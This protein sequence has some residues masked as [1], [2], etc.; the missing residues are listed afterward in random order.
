M[1]IPKTVF[2]LHCPKL[3]PERKK[4]LSR[5]LAERVP[6]RDIRWCEDY[7][8]D[9][10]FVE[11][12]KHTQKLPY[13][14]KITSGLVKSL[15]IFKTMID[16]DIKTSIILNDDVL[17]HKDWLPIINSMFINLG[18]AFYLDIKPEMGKMYQIPNNGGCEGVYVTKK[19]AQLYLE[20]LNMNYTA[21]IMVHGFLHMFGHPLLCIPICYQTSIMCKTTSLD[22]ETRTDGQDWPKF[23]YE[24]AT[25]KKLNYFQLLKDFEEYCKIK[26]RK[27]DKIFELYG[28]RL[29]LRYID[30]VIGG[31]SDFCNK[32]IE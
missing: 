30:Y 6:I 7:N 11:W 24:Y 18:T 4:F 23:V 9:H 13:G 2:V 28:A 14:P 5:H 19:F 25:S 26:K 16:E 20:N 32:I 21:D 12:L 15:D 22:H 31:G 3:N 17:F 29:D 1:K 27:E 10:H 8:H